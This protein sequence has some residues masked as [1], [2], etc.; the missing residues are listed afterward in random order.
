MRLRLLLILLLACAAANAQLYGTVNYCPSEYAN[1]FGS[2]GQVYGTT[3]WG[4]KGPYCNATSTAEGYVGS[5]SASVLGQCLVV[6][7]A[8]SVSYPTFPAAG[9][10]GTWA[11]SS[12]IG[13]V[14]SSAL[15]AGGNATV[16]AIQSG[17]GQTYLSTGYCTTGDT[18]ESGSWSGKC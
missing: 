9:V 5:I 3:A 17:F 18:V 12:T 14:N 4:S 11:C 10:G 7:F 15:A 13:Y 2:S 1:A 6:D 8:H 16:T